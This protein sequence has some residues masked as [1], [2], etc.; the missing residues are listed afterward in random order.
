MIKIA[1]GFCLLCVL[2]SCSDMLL[3]NGKTKGMVSFLISAVFLVSVLNLTKG[4]NVKLGG[5]QNYKM[6]KSNAAYGFVAKETIGALLTDENVYYEN[7]SVLTNNTE[8]D[9]IIISKVTV[10]TNQENKEKAEKVIKN[11][12]TAKTVEVISEQ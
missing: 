2:L 3:P 11:K 10:Y 1:T 8:E 6:E 4:I 12:T 7:L 9:G 5:I